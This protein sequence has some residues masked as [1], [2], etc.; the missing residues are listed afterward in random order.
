MQRIKLFT[1]VSFLV[2]SSCF[3]V[4]AMLGHVVRR[5]TRKTKVSK[6]ELIVRFFNRQKTERDIPRCSWGLKR[7][8]V[9]F[10]MTDD[11]K[12]TVAQL[13][14]V[15]IDAQ[16]NKQ[17]EIL[18][19]VMA[20]ATICGLGNYPI[21]QELYD[22]LSKQQGLGKK[23]FSAVQNVSHENMVKKEK[24]LIGSFALV[25]GFT[26]QCES[27]FPGRY[28]ASLVDVLYGAKRNGQKDIA[29]NAIRYLN[30][31]YFSEIGWRNLNTQLSGKLK[32]DGTYDKLF[33]AIKDTPERYLSDNVLETKL[34]GSF[35]SVKRFSDYVANDFMLYVAQQM[36]DD[37]ELQRYVTQAL[38]IASIR[39]KQ[40]IDSNK[41]DI[42]NNKQSINYN[43]QNIRRNRRAANSAQT[44]A[45]VA[46][47][48]AFSSR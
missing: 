39:N 10:R 16:K 6:N 25:D 34:L 42:G 32:A 45:I 24:E 13:V 30:L 3:E 19:N 37:P 15:I 2:G 22:Q 17:P 27:C 12:P 20:Y 43:K 8:W 38:V 36:K 1:L 31:C 33:D 21:H 29:L 35:A 44:S 28:R 11:K 9:K 23:L 14:E 47:S 4:S 46:Q 26:R 18:S 7:R 40:A 41:Q 5:V 48:I